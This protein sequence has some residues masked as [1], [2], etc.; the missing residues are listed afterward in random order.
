MQLK[1]SKPPAVCCKGLRLLYSTTFTYNLN[2]ST[3]S[4]YNMLILENTYSQTLLGIPKD[5]AS[6]LLFI[7]S[8][9][10]F[11]QH[12]NQAQPRVIKRLKIRES[13]VPKCVIFFFGSFVSLLLPGIWL[14][15]LSI[16]FL[17]SP[18]API[19]VGTVFGFVMV[20]VFL[21]LFLITY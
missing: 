16:S 13:A 4:L 6:S 9:F 21:N 12:Y 15:T 20:L 8:E 14:M 7:F 10:A 11:L 1:W 5:S 3:T 19:I 18:S 17:T 2:W